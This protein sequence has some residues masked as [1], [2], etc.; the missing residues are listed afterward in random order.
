MKVICNNDTTAKTVAS[1]MCLL[2][3]KDTIDPLQSAWSVLFLPI[4][5]VRN[6]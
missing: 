4:V 6:G 2:L 3:K 5:R 1:Q